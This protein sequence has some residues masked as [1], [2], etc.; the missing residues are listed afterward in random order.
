MRRLLPF[1]FLL[2]CGTP[3]DPASHHPEAPSPEASGDPNQAARLPQARELI[4]TL[5]APAPADTVPV[6]FVIQFSTAIVEGEQVAPPEWIQSP[7]PADGTA[8][9]WAPAGTVLLLEPPIPW[10]H[11]ITGPSTIMVVPGQPMRP[12][13]RYALTLSSVGTQWGPVPLPEPVSAAWTV[14]TFR[15]VRGAIGQIEPGR[16]TI[17]LHFAAPVDVEGLKRLVTL[18]VDGR[19]AGF[20]LGSSGKAEVATLVLSQTLNVGQNVH[21]VLQEGA[22]WAGPGGELI[23]PAGEA[24]LSVPVGKPMRI[25][26]TELTETATGWSLEVAC[27]DSAAEGWHRWWY[28]RPQGDWLEVSHR[29]LPTEASFATMARVDPGVALSVG[30]T[31][32]GFRVQGAWTKGTYELV[33]PSGLQ[34]VDGG[35]LLSELRAPLSIPARSPRV[36]FVSKGRYLPRSAWKKLP[37]RHVNTGR[38][39]VDVRLVPRQN[40]V[41][42]LSQSDEAADDRT[43][44]GVLH[45]QVAVETRPEE[46]VTTWL[47]L[48]SLVPQAANGVY[49]VSVAAGGSRDVAR[50]VVTDLQIVA[51]TAATAPG[52]PYAREVVA[53]VLDARTTQALSGVQL[54]LVRKSGKTL[55]EC[56]TAADGG[57]SLKINPDPADPSPPY[58]ILASRGEDLTYLKFDDLRAEVTD[59]LVQGEPFLADQPYRIAPWSDRGVYRPGDTMH[60]A[61]VLR[62]RFDVAPK[63]PV[64]VQVAVVDSRGNVVSRR[65]LETNASGTVAM[66]WTVS[67]S[68]PTGRWAF[69]WEVGGRQLAEQALHVEEFVPERMKV[70]AKHQAT[71]WIRG[72]APS[73]AVSA[74]YL[75]GGSA[76][77]APVELR[78]E[79]EPG[80]F[81]PKEWAT[82]AFGRWHEPDETPKSV[83][84]GAS[85]GELDLHG[86]TTLNCP[87]DALSGWEGIGTLVA[88]AVV[89]EG[90]SGRS[91][92]VATSVPWLPSPTLVGLD[93]GTAQYH[94]G[95]SVK[96]DGVVV[97]ADGAFVTDVSTAELEFFR[98][99]NEYGFIYDEGEDTEAWR[100]YLRRV[101]DGSATATV[102][103]GKFSTQITMKESGAGY[104]VRAKVGDAVTELMIEGDDSWS[105]WSEGGEEG[106]DTTPRPGKPRSV[107]LELPDRIEVGKASEILFVAPWRGRAL[108]TVETHRVLE[109]KWIEVQPGPVRWSW[110]L[111]R[112]A[113]NVYASV[114]LVKDPHLESQE[115]WLPDRA[116][117]VASAPVRATESEMEVRLTVLPEVRPDSDLSVTLDVGIQNAG[118][119]ATIAAVD[120]GILQLTKFES[121]DPNKI[122]FAQRALGVETFET[123]GWMLMLPAAGQSSSTGGDGEGGL[124]QARPVKP[125]A[126]WSGLLPI[127]TDGK[128]TAILHVPRYQ[129]ELRVMAVVVGPKRAGSASQAVPVRDPLVLQATLPRFLTGGDRFFVPVS[130]TNMTG[131][132]RTVEVTLSAEGLP[133]GGAVAAVDAGK[134]VEIV[135]KAQQTLALR[136]GESGVAVFTGEAIATVGAARF[137]VEAR[138]GEVSSY[139]VLEVPLRSAGPR[140]RMVQ[141]IPVEDGDLVLASALGGWTPT[142]ETTTFWLTNN[143]FGDLFDHIRY[144]I[145]YPYGC[146]EQ[147]TSS[148]RPLLYISRFVDQ[149]DPS[150]GRAAIADKVRAGIQRVLTMQT[151]EGGF[152]YWPGDT[153]PV[154]WGTA[155][156]LHLLIDAKKAQYDVPED[157]ITRAADWLAGDVQRQS[158]DSGGADAYP[159]YV[160]ALAQRANKG[161]TQA[162]LDQLDPNRKG[163]V[164]E[165]EYLL[166][167]ALWLAG[168][169]RFEG[170]LKNPD[171]TAPTDERRN[172]WI[173]W[174][175]RRRLALTLAV[176]EDLFGIDP[177]ADALASLVADSLRAQRSYTTQEVAWGV[178]ALGRRVAEGTKEA[179]KGELLSGGK[180]LLAAPREGSKGGTWIVQRASERKDLTFRLSGKGAG[181]LYLMTS[182][183]G[184]RTN[185]RWETGGQGLRIARHYLRDD[186][187]PLPPGARLKLGEMVTVIIEVS[188]T[189]A[190]TILNVAAVDRFAAGWEIENPRLGRDGSLAG[191][192]A[193]KLWNIAHMNI[194]DDRMEVFGS[195]PAG[196]TVQVAYGLRAV[197]AGTFTIPP[198]E[199]EAMYE[200]RLWARAPGGVAFVD[201]PWGEGSSGL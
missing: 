40:L 71:R 66:D 29:C 33:L 2:A 137:R 139:D 86:Q 136:A 46:E 107:A 164:A 117:G 148:T 97:N 158:V 119:F 194:K 163:P 190:S 118:A 129:G 22:R 48:A 18:E 70:E 72:E 32:Y 63:Q 189:T 20:T 156:G 90:G 49:Q 88:R 54:K 153:H 122:L 45:T 106:V 96:V 100:R 85:S 121:P 184:V 186:G 150:L 133:L 9:P 94:A 12:G 138:A 84:L 67:D 95:D 160:L 74:R 132:D 25:V 4:P 174:S 64:P 60:V 73:V 53:W 167:A 110:K 57:C 102:R 116:F 134:P 172:D 11:A 91:S 128:V 161:R 79:V 21:V 14:P 61:A 171:L 111:D 26:G 37:I 44:D 149:V 3:S 8:P 195:L 179:G 175:D 124:A 58:A 155:Y 50:L 13:T 146:I 77:G 197:T 105:W 147:T 142:T 123:I 41:Y 98:L 181:M 185:A 162:V 112:F 38:I 62:D 188:N 159:L 126:L 92:Q 166:R 78:C 99:E 143:P 42:W 35:V 68:A 10:R 144:L 187:T 81:A 176:H 65:S 201:P 165:A 24:Q 114:F 183:E 140:T 101:A 82:W 191:V 113:P 177:S 141:R 131:K 169:R 69:R 198:V 27:D 108:I 75:F 152:A 59:S 125:V 7:P 31:R 109:A 127:G 39:D 43:S 103:G 151:P 180:A 30:P 168:D 80:R 193:E 76:E 55:A 56:Q 17:D 135:G 200:P 52:D 192:S 36:D 115:A 120:E 196:E 182:S 1:Y 157:A 16:A 89:F 28:N 130:V 6:G 51:K 145:Q 19:R 34:T 154:Q 15:L 23:A 87:T 178:M 170:P 104:L 47:D 93:S 83:L 173:F 199:A 5:A